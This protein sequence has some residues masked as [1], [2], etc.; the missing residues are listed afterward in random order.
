MLLRFSPFRVAH[1]AVLLFTAFA[2]TM[3]FGAS[4]RDDAGRDVVLDHP[5]RRIVSLAPHLT[6]LVFEIGAG[7]RLVAAAAYSDYPDAARRLPRVGSQGALDIE[8]I[9]ALRPDLVLAWSSGLSPTDREQLA[10][11]GVP[12]FES[13]AQELDDVATTLLRLGVLTGAEARAGS[14]AARFRVRVATLRATYADRR[15]VRVFFQVWR[16]PLMTVGGHQ[17]ITQ[18]IALCGGVNVFGDLAMLAPIVDAEAVV[19]GDPEVIATTSDSDDHTADIAAWSRWPGVAAVRARRFA[20][21]DAG[22]IT[23]PSSRVLIGTEQLCRAIDAA[24]A[25]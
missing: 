12:V 2:T 7:D 3:A 14:A 5:A 11:L 23:R 15:P 9:A 16:D 17:L 19:R 1:H 21:L 25:R 22:T 4:V 24:R 10:R 18:V 6:E 8:R 13:T 20:F